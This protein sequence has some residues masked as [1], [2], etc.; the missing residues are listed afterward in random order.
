[1]TEIIF[2]DI[3][4]FPL[5]EGVSKEWVAG[6][7]AEGKN[8]DK[9]STIINDAF[10]Y[11]VEA[12]VEVP[13]YPQYQDMNEQFLSIIRD[14]E[15][16]EE[17]FKV[18]VDAARIMEL[19]SIE[20][21]AKAYL[22]EN[23]KKLDVRICVTGPLELYLKEFGGTEY[24]DILNLFG[25]S[26]DRF[27]KNSISNAKSFNIKTVSI[28]EPSIGINPQVM[29]DDNELITAMDGACQSASKNG[30]DVE[31]HLHSP[32][33]YTLACQAKNISVIGVESA[34]TPSYLELID[35]KVLED[36]DSFLRVGVART[37]IFNLVAVLNEKYN[38]NVW[39]ETQHFPE[40]INEMET[41]AVIAKRLAHAHSIFGERIKYAGPD[42]GLGSWPSQEIASQLLRN[43]AAGISDFKK[44]L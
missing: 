13:T 2:D 12:G 6:K 16:C 29:F 20:S 36:S 18:K 33:H 10:N 44:S 28:D 17:P 19:E 21:V 8:D 34:A 41:P 3:G 5:P 27:V 39:K 15:N 23:G 43:V 22:E 30:C 38:T 1:M 24:V 25:E 42:C 37:D 14:S 32:L 7:F 9:L 40:I 11:K 35:K 31:I 4:S 26:I